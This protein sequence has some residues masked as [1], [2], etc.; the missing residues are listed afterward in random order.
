MSELGHVHPIIQVPSDHLPYEFG[1]PDNHA[2]CLLY[3]Y[4]F[5]H[6]L[7]HKLCVFSDLLA[8]SHKLIQGLKHL[9]MVLLYQVMPCQGYLRRALREP[10]G[11][12]EPGT[13]VV[14]AGKGG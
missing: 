10:T 6:H 4:R 2:H 7:Q 8:G 13:T 1:P 3:T 12:E 11:L 14:Q 9:I 5:L